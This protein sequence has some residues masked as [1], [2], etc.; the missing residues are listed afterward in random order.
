MIINGRAVKN[1]YGHFFLFL[2]Q[3]LPQC[4]AIIDFLKYVV[5]VNPNGA[6]E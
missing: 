5:Q 2:F 4:N 3:L 6:F 1:R